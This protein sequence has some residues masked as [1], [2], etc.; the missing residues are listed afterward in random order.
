MREALA[1]RCGDASGGERVVANSV[2]SSVLDAGDAQCAGKYVARRRFERNVQACRHVG[3]P[4]TAPSCRTPGLDKG[5]DIAQRLL[6]LFG[7]EPV[8]AGRQRIKAQFGRHP[9][10]CL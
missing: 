9:A 4:S 5:L 1:G 3:I 2:D 8:N 6:A 7:C 10:D